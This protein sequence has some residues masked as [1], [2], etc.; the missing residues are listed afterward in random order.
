MVAVG[1]AVAAAIR[2]TAVPRDV[3][4]ATAAQHPA[5]TLFRPGRIYDSSLLLTRII[6]FIIIPIL[7]PLPN[8]AVH[9][10]KS[11]GIRRITAHRCCFVR[12]F[13]LGIFVIRIVAIVIGLVCGQV[14]AGIER[15]GSAGPA[16]IF[17]LR[18]G[19]Q[20]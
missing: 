3:A 16:G 14:F 15:C 18:F 19:R 13:T 6:I 7:A 2:R 17:P 9:I 1:G 12:I 11:P 5:R 8:I 10:A 20:A 4:P